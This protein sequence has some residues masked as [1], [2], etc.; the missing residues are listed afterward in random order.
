VLDSTKTTKTPASSREES[1]ALSARRQRARSSADVKALRQA[2]LHKLEHEVGADPEQ[3]SE[4]DWFAA[5]ALALRDRMIDTWR[6]SARRADKAGAKRAYYLSLEFLIGRLL[7]DALC[8]LGLTDTAR[9]ALAAS[10]SISTASEPQSPMRR[11]ATAAS[12]G[13][14]PASWRAWHPCACLRSATA[15]ATITACSGRASPMDGRPKHRTHGSCEATRGSL[16][17]PSSCI[18]FASEV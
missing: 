9:E 7:S 17:G 6:A 13:S 14:P 11:W 8:N 18:R 12:G 2:I 3:P 10:A 1:P 4:H 16:S 5:T 15:S